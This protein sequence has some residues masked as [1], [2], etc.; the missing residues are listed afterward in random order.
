[1]SKQNSSKLLRIR[2]KPMKR[3]TV[4]GAV[5]I[6]GVSLAG[7]FGLQQRLG[8]DDEDGPSQE[9]SN[10]QDQDSNSDPSISADEANSTDTPPEEREETQAQQEE[11][12][13]SELDEE[14][15]TQEGAENNESENE[16][17]SEPTQD[18]PDG[19]PRD[20]IEITDHQ[21]IF[22]EASDPTYEQDQLYAQGILR[23]T[24]D[25]PL[26]DV[27]VDGYAYASGEEVGH[28]FVEYA[29]IN[30]TGER[31]FELPFYV[32]APAEVEEYTLTVSAASWA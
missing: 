30:G 11:K 13:Q 32:D 10:Q 19:D 2:T 5:G 24:V 28:E 29:Y 8:S 15:S 6:G 26:R 20:A 14:N 17:G 21:M 25:H 3:R 23:N 4:L 12:N 31:R 22:E 9:E 1:M 16:N 7:C 27:R 18:T